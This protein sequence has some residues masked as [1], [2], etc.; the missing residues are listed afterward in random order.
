MSTQTTA[1]PKSFRKR[2]GDRIIDEL[3]APPTREIPEIVFVDMVRETLQRVC[4][5]E[6]MRLTDSAMEDLQDS[7]ESNLSYVFKHAN[8]NAQNDNRGDICLEDFNAA[9]Q[10]C[11]SLFT[12]RKHGVTVEEDPTIS[13]SFE[14]CDVSEELD[15]DDND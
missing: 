8:F 11:G 10:S 6:G 15:P 1:N 2:S 9:L 4:G 5:P 7:F 12:R 3:R 13:E 14:H